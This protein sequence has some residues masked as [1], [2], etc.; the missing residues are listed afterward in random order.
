MIRT[1]N[2]SISDMESYGSS[3]TIG[4]ATKSQEEPITRY[5]YLGGD[6]APLRA[7]E[8]IT[9][10]NFRFKDIDPPATEHERSSQNK[11]KDPS[12][13]PASD[14][15]KSR[16]DFSSPSATRSL[17]GQK[18]NLSGYSPEELGDASAS[19][20]NIIRRASHKARDNEDRRKMP[21]PPG[22]PQRPM[23]AAPQQTGAFRRP[24]SPPPR[25]R[26]APKASYTQSANDMYRY[27][28]QEYESSIQRRLSEHGGMEYR[29][30][31]Y[32]EPKTRDAL[33]YQAAGSSGPT[34]PLT[35]EMLRKASRRNPRSQSNRD[36]SESRPGRTTGS[37]HSSSDSG[38]EDYA[39]IKV[40]GATL[41]VPRGSEI[42]VGQGQTQIRSADTVYQTEDG[43]LS[44]QRRTR[45]TRDKSSTKY[46]NEAGGSSAQQQTSRFTDRRGKNPHGVR[47]ETARP[48]GQQQSRSPLVQDEEDIGF[49]D[50]HPTELL[51]NARTTR[52]LSSETSSMTKD[53]LYATDDSEGLETRLREETAMPSY[54]Q[55]T[56]PAQLA[57]TA[58]PAETDDVGQSS[59]KDEET[60]QTG[61]RTAVP[62]AKPR[63][64]MLFTVITSRVPDYIE[65]AWYPKGLFSDYTLDQLKQEIGLVQ[66]DQSKG[67]I[68]RLT[69]PGVDSITL[70]RP[71]SDNQFEIFKKD[72]KIGILNG[73][74]LTGKS[75]SDSEATFR[76]VIEDWSE[77]DQLF[78][79]DED[80]HNNVH[81]GQE[82]LRPGDWNETTSNIRES[83]PEQNPPGID[84]FLSPHLLG[85][86][87]DL[88]PSIKNLVLPGVDRQHMANEIITG[89]QVEYS[90]RFQPGQ[91]RLLAPLQITCD[92]NRWFFFLSSFLDI[93]DILARTTG[94][95]ERCVRIIIIGWSNSGGP[96]WQPDLCRHSAIHH[97]FQRCG[98]LPVSVS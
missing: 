65:Y 22:I 28:H 40:G 83:E 98:P 97:H 70:L 2:M 20:P 63:V 47:H 49:D 73:L 71:G 36:D 75:V 52:S 3:R 88:D 21:P 10:D 38:A 66:S 91:V 33:Y 64:R 7:S 87:T 34:I 86:Y 68:F 69:G 31:Y 37:A 59:A 6:Q 43:T 61:S 95:H 78:S 72:V 25:H 17:A 23:S 84:S 42:T 44:T 90:G 67:I 24:V 5:S 41:K 74:K 56:Q 46:P 50:M 55:A 19:A 35:A 94:G 32:M 62:R 93:Q 11:G 8:E 80:E 89:Y 45:S 16:L 9:F 53:Q 85:D 57:A 77:E 29:E 39:T 79:R 96:V 82:P 76:L 12:Y 30:H 4:R 26:T 14:H 1:G 48:R 13:H 15:W 58:E 54:H 81:E 92:A 18:R 27:N 60:H 51:T